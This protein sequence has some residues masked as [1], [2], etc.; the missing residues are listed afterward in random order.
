[1]FI[2]K[3]CS[4]KDLP[5]RGTRR[6][7]LKC[8]RKYTAEWKENRPEK[9][10]SYNKQ[11]SVKRRKIKG[12][13]VQ[14]LGGKCQNEPQCYYP[15]IEGIDP[16]PETMH[17]HHIEQ[18][19]KEMDISRRLRAGGLSSVET[20]EDMRRDAPELVAEL[21]KC[22]LLCGNCHAHLEYCCLRLR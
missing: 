1:M 21:D 10:R 4:G 15:L 2:C 6:I 9:Q 13:C 16:C 18:E 19:K 22:R 8:E 3:L 17:F 11:I 20:I 12:I 5:R 14:Y 7:C